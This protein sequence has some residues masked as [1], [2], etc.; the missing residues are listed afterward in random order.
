VQIKRW[1][2]YLTLISCGLGILLVWTLLAQI[3]YRTQ[4]GSTKNANLINVIN[5]MEKDTSGLEDQI[6]I[7]RQKLDVAQK[8][9]LEN[10]QLNQLQWLKTHAGML[11]VIGPGISIVL[12]D[13]KLGAAAAQATKSDTYQPENYII[14]DKN[15]LYLVYEL[16]NA[17]AEAIAI[18]NQRI[19]NSSTIRCVG[20]VIMVNSTY[21]APPYEIIAIGNPDNLAQVLVNGE[22]FTY[23]KSKDFPVKL[24]KKNSLVI[25]S[26]KGTYSINYANVKERSN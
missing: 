9:Q 14:H 15:L 20:S 13:N 21:L 3:A 7:L 25:P 17:G 2:L 5:Q 6:G 11:E 8:N 26:Y 12:D 19:I 22:E 18:N 23:L 1:H 10:G 24:T 4:A 16:K